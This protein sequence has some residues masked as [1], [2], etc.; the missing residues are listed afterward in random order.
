M[1][2]ESPAPVLPAMGMKAFLL[3]AAIVSLF[4]ATGPHADAELPKK[5]TEFDGH[6][7]AIDA[8]SITVKGDKGTRKFQIYPGTVFGQRAS[9]KLADFTV[10]ERVHVVFSDTAGQVKAENIRN[11]E[12]DRK[13]PAKKR[14][15]AKKQ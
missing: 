15:K 1:A 7:A 9:R 12:E 2:C 8:A 10:G 3:P 5:N 6:I 11:P 13:K 4:L 14:P